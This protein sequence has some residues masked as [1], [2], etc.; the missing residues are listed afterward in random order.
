MTLELWSDAPDTTAI[1]IRPGNADEINP[2]LRRE[3]YL[4]PL[5]SGQTVLVGLVG[6]RVVAGQVWKLPTSRHLPFDGTWLELSRWCLTRDA[7]ENAGSKFH[8]A[9]VRYLRKT[10]AKVTTLV[11]YSDPSVGHTGALYRACNWQWAPTWLRLRPPPTG[12]GA[13]QDGNT[14]AAKDRWV[15]PIR[16]DAKRTDLCEVKDASA[17]RHWIARAG[18]EELRM[19]VRSAAPDLVAAARGVI[20]SEAA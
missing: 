18:A 17:I 8:A 16:R 3:H 19:A 13:W 4:G 20:G 15:F 9:A 14:Q 6:G 5:D 11:S 7:G 12:H 2:M 10:D 1:H